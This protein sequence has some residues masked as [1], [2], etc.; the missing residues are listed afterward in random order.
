M[1]RDEIKLTDKYSFSLA[2]TA[3]LIGVSYNTLRRL[4][5]SGDI[6]SVR[7]GEK[8]ILVPAD[9]LRKYLNQTRG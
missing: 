5:R 3:Q 9:G 8:R 4:V 6:P 1:T 7:V 2:E